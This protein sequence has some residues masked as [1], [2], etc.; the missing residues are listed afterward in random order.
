M[1]PKIIGCRSSG[2]LIQMRERSFSCSLEVPSTIFKPVFQR[3]NGVIQLVLWFVEWGANDQY[4][5]ESDENG[6]D[7]NS[8]RRN[9][10]EIQGHVGEETDG[11]TQ[12]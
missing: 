2:L 7:Q 5:A 12:E 10:R 6:R 3:Y 1:G 11:E 4:G 8:L 9:Y